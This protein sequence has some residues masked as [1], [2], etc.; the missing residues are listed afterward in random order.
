[1]AR[2][3]SRKKGR[4]SSTK[5][6]K[7]EPPAWVPMSPA[8]IERLIVKLAGEGLSSSMIGMKLRDQYGVPNVKLSTGKSIKEILEE[9]GKI[10]KLPEDLKNLMKT[11]VNL[12]EHLSE[13]PKDLHNTRALALTEAKIRRLMKYYKRKGI[14][15][16]DWKYD[17]KSAKLLVE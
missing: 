1:M 16:Q 17:L 5:P 14:L 3:H 6:Y 7:T 10:Q 8:E 15:P 2:I 13:N 11:A 12:D 4:S 9:N